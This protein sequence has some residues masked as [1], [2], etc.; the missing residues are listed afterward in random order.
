MNQ[1]KDESMAEEERISKQSELYWQQWHKQQ[2]NQ[3]I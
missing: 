2:V 1:K 3:Y